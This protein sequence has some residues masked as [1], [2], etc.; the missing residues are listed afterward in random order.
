MKKIR[1]ILLSIF[2][3]VL[4]LF[5]NKVYAANESEYSKKL[6]YQ[7]AT[8]N[9]D[10][11]VSVKEVMW[12]N[13]E[14]NGGK[15]EIEFND[16]SK[17]SFTGIYSNFSGDT[18]I[19]NATKIS[20]VKVFDISQEN[21]NSIEDINNLEKEF[22]KVEDAS[23]G[24]Y[25][26]YTVTENGYE[27]NVTIYC[28]S[29]KKK[30][31]YLE[32][33]IENAVVVHNDVAELYWCF[34]ENDDYEV[35]YDYKLV[36]H[37]P[38]EDNNVMVWSHGPAT[39][40]CSIADYKTLTLEDTNIAPY[41]YETLRIMFDKTLVPNATKLS[42]VNGKEHIIK[43]ENA[44][45][46]PNTA[47]IETEKIYI[48]NRLNDLL[49]ELDEEPYI[50][51]YNSANELLEKITWDDTLKNQYKEKLNSYKESVNQKWKNS[52]DWEIESMIEFNTI[53]QS[54]IDYLIKK[55]DE[56]FDENAKLEYYNKANELQEILNERIL[57]MQQTTLKIVTILYYV[58]GII[59]ILKLIKL[60]FEKR[61]YY[62]KYYR[63]FPSDDN[64]Y[65]IDYLMTKKVTSK[66]FIVTIL[67]L[68]SKGQISL[69]KNPNIENDIIFV[70]KKDTSTLTKVEKNVIELLFNKI[71]SNNKC[72]MHELKNYGTVR[73]NSDTMIKYLEKFSKSVEEHV[74]KKEYF[75]KDNKFNN[76]LK[77]LINIICLISI[78]LGFFIKGNGYISVLN[79]YLIIITLSIIFKK[80]ISFDKNRTKKGQM[81]YSKWLAH[82]RFLKDFGKF[83]EKALPEIIL[84]DRYF[85]TA[86]ILDCANQVLD[87]MEISVVDYEALDELQSMLWQ[88]IHYQNMKTLQ[89]SLNSLMNKAT[90]YS[91]VTIS[92]SSGSG[93][94]DHTY[95][96]G[97]GFG[98]GSAS[99]GSGGGGGGWSRF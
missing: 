68:V 6:L 32:Y 18:D 55:I 81:E 35:I 5:T 79:Y 54:S 59:C 51:L 76:F 46:D 48:E 45:A 36:V 85:V 27:V 91:R 29:K 75:K 43:Y 86:V 34:L 12:L 95:S 41:K 33:T 14:Y 52:V 67:D 62:H 21:F 72:S 10:G 15:R 16:S 50:F 92:S 11:S 80:I 3:F 7:D 38:Q 74:R 53:S 39:G 44:M 1:I 63:D 73:K 96:S 57:K 40:Y 17:Y 25:G 2:V 64:A 19:Y 89:R 24:K 42:N 70:L 90:A 22:K 20:N 84:W 94:R 61:S 98:G 37:L 9:A 13:G 88:Y 97:G 71:G 60:F 26:V 82:K 28:P 83:D 4:F 66:T 47:E 65:I 49:L 58:L 87:K 23:K 77:K 78:I 93:G 30:V 99:G 56:G 31:L 8:I 69:E